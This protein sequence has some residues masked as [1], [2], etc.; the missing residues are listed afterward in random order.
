M[1]P[2]SVYALCVLRAHGLPQQYLNDVFRATVQG[3]LL[4][5]ASAWFGYCTAGDKMRLNS[6]LRKCWKLGYSDRN[7]TFEDIC[8]DADEHLFNRLIHKIQIMYSTDCYHHPI[9]RLNDTISELTG[10]HSSYQSTTLAYKTLI[11]FSLECYIK[12]DI[13]T[14]KTIRRP[15]SFLTRAIFPF[16]VLL[17][18]FTSLWNL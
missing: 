3:K 4:C 5:A 13:S 14:T 11:T 18:F 17:V 12:T 16:I 6:F 1:L 9:Q 7:M 2:T 15:T 10:T 8:A